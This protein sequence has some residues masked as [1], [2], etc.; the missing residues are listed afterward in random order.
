MQSV[1]GAFS[2]ISKTIEVRRTSIMVPSKSTHSPAREQFL[3]IERLHR[4]ERDRI[5]TLMTA[6]YED[7]KRFCEEQFEAFQTEN[8]RLL[9]EISASAARTR[10]LEDQLNSM[11][12]TASQH[13]KVHSNITIITTISTVTTTI[14]TITTRIEQWKHIVTRNKG[15]VTISIKE[16]DQLSL[17]LYSTSSQITGL[18]E[19]YDELSRD[20]SSVRHEQRVTLSH[21]EAK[22]RTIASLSAEVAQWKNTDAAKA[23]QITAAY[24]DNETLRHHL[25]AASSRTAELQ[26]R[27]DAQSSDLVSA[28]T[29]LQTKASLI[30]ERDRT[31]ASFIA[32]VARWEKSDAT[33]AEQIAT[34]RQDYE[35]LQ[36]DLSVA[37]SKTAE[38]QNRYDA[39]SKELSSISDELQA[40]KSLVEEKER[41]ITALTAEVDQWK[42]ADA[43]KAERFAAEDRDKEKLQ[44]DLASFSSQIID[45]QKRYD[46]RSQ[47][48]VSVRGELQSKVSLLEEKEHV[49]SSL[50]AEL[51]QAKREDSMK[52]EQLATARTDVEQ[53]RLEL[54]SASSRIADLQKRYEAKSEELNFVHDKCHKM[55]I[56]YPDGTDR[57]LVEPSEHAV[58]QH[59]SRVLEK[60]N[61]EI[62]ELRHDLAASTTLNIEL[63]RSYEA[64][65]RDVSAVHDE[66][67]VRTSQDEGTIT[68]L[69]AQ[70]EQWK[71]MDAMK[72]ERIMTILGQA[73]K[74]QIDLST[75][76]SQLSELQVRYETQS[77]E[78]IAVQRELQTRTSSN[79]G[80]DRTIVSLSAEVDQ[81]KRADAEKAK[82]IT[83]TLK[84]VGKL[85]QDLTASISELAELRGHYE[86]Q[87]HELISV[88]NE[89]Q[90]KI[91]LHESKDHTIVSLAAEV[92]QWKRADATKA[93]QIATILKRIEKLQR[94]LSV[95]TSQLAELQGRYEAQSHEFVSVHNEL[96][97]RTS[98]IEEK[99][100]IVV[101]L[102][103]QVE[104]WK[105]TDALKEERIVTIWQQAEDLQRDLTSSSSQIAVLQQRYRMQSKEL[106]SLQCQVSGK[107]RIFSVLIAILIFLF[108]VGAIPI[109]IITVVL[110]GRTS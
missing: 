98:S 97:I 57:G 80:K 4:E 20:F 84:Q 82:H 27:Y 11:A 36:R 35:R 70:V 108:V 55:E 95:S 37:S 71:R 32:E 79:E 46:A 23:Q 110:R 93:E 47:D 91:S 87:S 68:S 21:H 101:I 9:R 88:R 34:A 86:A 48:V 6:E 72:A 38:L 81:W 100:R 73:E 26:Q 59:I 58:S 94:D 66:L 49:A 28:R 64:L 67:K 14:T 89:L 12:V 7:Y 17:E 109:Y 41:R 18:Q 39:Q 96:Q 60:K 65:S 107:C 52:A 83:M 16:L 103:A 10:L 30:E 106:R 54:Y 42:L 76:I 2:S 13:D 92:D 85:H 105:R 104:E 5:V 99:E 78:F 29:E 77:R 56:L 8:E 3:Q 40:N 44:Q 50:I 24:R 19:R 25:S 62:E 102:T 45:L 33:N 75:S 61:K 51:A 53:L 69:T 22:D 15:Q 43:T 74:L 63:Q 90:A 31:I 1:A